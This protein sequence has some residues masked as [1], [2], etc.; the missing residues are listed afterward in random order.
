[1][2]VVALWDAVNYCKSR[3][4]FNTKC[5]LPQISVMTHA[6]APCLITIFS[7]KS[8]KLFTNRLPFTRQLR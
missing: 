5:Q 3:L 7:C 4:W 2:D 1:M 6:P 8:V